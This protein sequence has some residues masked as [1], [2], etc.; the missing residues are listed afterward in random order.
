[1]ADDETERW[2]LDLYAMPVWVRR[3]LL[4]EAKRQGLSKPKQNGLTAICKVVLIAAA[5]QFAK[6]KEK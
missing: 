5:R 6:K 1:M 3:E 4:A 2:N